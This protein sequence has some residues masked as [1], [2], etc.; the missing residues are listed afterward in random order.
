[1]TLELN[2]PISTIT[3]EV[4]EVSVI[5][6]DIVNSSVIIDGAGELVVEHT[7]SSI[8]VNPTVQSEITIENPRSQVIIG[9]DGDSGVNTF[10]Q[11]LD[12]PNGKA[13]HALKAVTVSADETELVFV[14]IPG[15]AS[16]AFDDLS[17]TPASKSGKAGKGLAVNVGETDLDYVDFVLDSVYQLHLAATNPHN[18]TAAQSGADPAGSAATVQGNLDTHEADTLNPH[19]VTAVQ[20]GADPVGSAATVQGNL[21]IHTGDTSNPH[22]VTIDDV[23]PLDNDEYITAK[24]LASSIRDILGVD[25][26]DNVSVGSTVLNLLLNG[27]AVHPQYF[28]G[29]STDDLALLAELN[30]HVSNVANPHA[31]TF[32]LL[33]DTP[34]S[35]F[36]NADKAVFVNGSAT[37]LQYRSIVHSDLNGLEEDDHKLYVKKNGWNIGADS[38]VTRSFTPGTRTFEIAPSGASFEYWCDGVL[39]TKTTAQSVVIDDLEGL[40]FIYFDG[41]TLIA[42]QTAWNIFDDDLALVSYLYWDATNNTHVGVGHEMHTWVM[43]PATHAHLHLAV[44]S[45]YKDGL[46]LGNMDVDGNG[47]DASA[48]RFSVGDGSFFDEDILN[49]IE[50]GAPQ[51]LTSVAEIPVLYRLGATGVWRKIPATTFPI[52]TTGGGRAA[53]NEFTGG[54]WQLTE[55]DNRDFV[56]MHIFGTNDLEEP[57]IAIMGQDEYDSK[58][59]ARAGAEVEMQS[60]L[61]GDLATLLPEFV[62]MATVIFETQDSYSNAVQSRVVST[63]EGDDYIDWRAT[64][65][66]RSA[67][68]GVTDHA[69]LTGITGNDHV[70]HTETA[71]APT[72]TEYPNDGDCGFHKDTTG[73][74]YYTVCNFG[75]VIKKALLT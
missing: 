42:S 65:G 16:Y 49:V 72:T 71:A 6:V 19:A 29:T 54:A 52:T 25:A 51:P 62:P 23:F 70:K 15:G 8:A 13:G 41:A 5:E 11:L 45:R 12:T 59:A 22:N 75:G 60:L 9:G 7:T 66:S 47:D 39:H 24:D 58:R 63:D 27:K 31:T 4:T 57:V 33:G 17:D 1:M 2:G 36:G 28:N 73:P 64:T 56:L 20:S 50:D 46:S 18:V 35:K 48:A 67:V 34:A 21:D 43:D 44:G 37:A 61:L 74:T 55:V 68:S 53:W 32:D 30:S 14:T 38:T 10:D 3:V 69:L 26:S 40:W